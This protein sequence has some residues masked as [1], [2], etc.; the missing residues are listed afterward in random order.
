VAYA[1]AVNRQVAFLPAYMS[2]S[3]RIH[4]EFLRLLFFLSNKHLS[5]KQADDYFAALG[6]EAHKEESCH[7]LGVFFYR[8][9]AGRPH[10]SPPITFDGPTL[11]R[12]VRV[13]RECV[14]YYFSIASLAGFRVFFGPVGARGVFSLINETF[15]HTTDSHTI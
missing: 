4:G 15:S 8:N 7:R 10:T 5:N 2:T 3:G 6:Y 11:A 12:V 9:A 1:Y 13:E 14:R